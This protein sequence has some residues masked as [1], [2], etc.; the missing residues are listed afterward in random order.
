MPTHLLVALSCLLLA[1][2]NGNGSG[3]GSDGGGGIGAPPVTL[4]D[5][6]AGQYNLGPVEFHGS[7]PNSCAPYPSEIS[8]AAG[9]MLAGVGLEFNG[10]GQLCDACITIDTA[11]G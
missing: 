9:D 1:C 10:H 5:K 8:T 11:R 4:G 2:E 6:H 7:I 3:S